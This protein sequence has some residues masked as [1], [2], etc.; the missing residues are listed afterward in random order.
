MPLRLLVTAS[1][2]WTR[3][4]AI[5]ATLT[6]FHA[7]YPGAVLVSGHARGGDSMCEGA[8][9]RLCGYGSRDAAIRAGRIEIYPADWEQYGKAAGMIRSQHMV[10][11]GPDYYV[12]FCN[13][14]IKR[15][16]PVQGEHGTHGTAAC[17]AMAKTAGI[18]EYVDGHP[19]PG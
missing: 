5:R 19:P 18:A 6:T 17:I 12:S 13:P 16:C 14:C 10:N 4:E 9:A 11:T 7:R 1:R 8:W 3:Y 2:D 15:D